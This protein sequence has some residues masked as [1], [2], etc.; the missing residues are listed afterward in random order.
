MW[1]SH[2]DARPRLGPAKSRGGGLAGCRCN[3]DE[4][5]V[6]FVL[7]R[8]ICVLFF[9]LRPVSEKSRRRAVGSGATHAY[10]CIAQHAPRTHCPS[11]PGGVEW[12]PSRPRQ[13]PAKSCGA[14]L[15]GC[16]CNVDDTALCFVDYCSGCCVCCSFHAVHATGRQKKLSCFGLWGD[17][18]TA[19]S[20]PH[21]HTAHRPPVASIDSLRM[22]DC[23]TAY[24]THSGR[25]AAAAAALVARA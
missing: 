11:R 8:L 5:A 21:A 3:I 20:T 9:F 14:G 17:T 6:C 18:C 25:A 22:T 13:R 4:T 7:T 2:V 1:R 24:I 16:R 12:Q 19:H 15:A 10:R 23:R